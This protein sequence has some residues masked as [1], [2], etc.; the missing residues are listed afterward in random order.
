MKRI[1]LLAALCLFTAPVKADFYH[2]PVN[3][4]WVVTGDFVTLGDPVLGIQGTFSFSFQATIDPGTYDWINGPF[5]GY[6]AT[7]RVNEGI[8][9]SCSSSQ[10]GSMC[11]RNLHNDPRFS[12]NDIDGDGI[13][14]MNVSGG[15]FST[16]VTISNFD[17]AISLPAGFT[18]SPY[19]AAVPEPSTWIMMLI[20]FLGMALMVKRDERQPLRWV[21]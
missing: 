15:A 5:Y 2:V 9:Q 13:A 4:N 19:I 7:V 14:F 6:S 17:V 21:G 10:I 8:A 16:N 18:I 20:G 3:S 12:I 1:L 11:G